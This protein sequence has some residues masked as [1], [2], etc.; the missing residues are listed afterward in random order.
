[1]NLYVGDR[2]MSYSHLMA[3]S[4]VAPICENIIVFHSKSCKLGF[5]VIIC[6]CSSE[7]F[8]AKYNENVHCR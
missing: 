6:D 5:C 3:L 2:K 1:M 7:D 8:G 4:V